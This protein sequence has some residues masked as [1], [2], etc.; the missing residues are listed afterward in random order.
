MCASDYRHCGTFDDLCSLVLSGPVV[1]VQATPASNTKS[2]SQSASARLGEV[3]VTGTHIKRTSVKAAQPITID[4]G[5]TNPTFERYGSRPS[6]LQNITQL[7]D[8][9]TLEDQVQS[10]VSGTATIDSCYFGSSRSTPQ[11]MVE[12]ALTANKINKWLRQ[13]YAD[14]RMKVR[15]N[16]QDT[17]TGNTN[18]PRN[19]QMRVIDQMHRS[20]TMMTLTARCKNERYAFSGPRIAKAL[21]QT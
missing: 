13:L 12:L 1:F 18:T 17:P 9:V 15:D 11:N 5:S 20:C 10:T 16:K 7:G 19:T 21:G 4:Y 14:F 6:L 2:Q 8:D 3:E